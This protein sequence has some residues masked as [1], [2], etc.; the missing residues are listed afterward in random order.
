M[1]HKIQLVRKFMSRFFFSTACFGSVPCRV[2]VKKQWEVM[3]PVL[4]IWGR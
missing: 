3:H 4:G 2:P 1:D